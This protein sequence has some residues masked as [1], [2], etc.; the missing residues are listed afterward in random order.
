MKDYIIL[1]HSDSD[2]TNSDDWSVYIA[3]LNQLGVFQGGS[4]IGSGAC[5][6]K[7]CIWRQVI[8]LRLSLYSNLQ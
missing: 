3:K 4:S 1:M 2:N 5:I 7:N 6:S 8:P